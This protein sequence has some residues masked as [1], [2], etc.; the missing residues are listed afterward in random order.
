MCFLFL[1]LDRNREFKVLCSFH[2]IAGVRLRSVVGG[3]P[4][5]SNE[6]D[7]TCGSGTEAKTGGNPLGGV[8]SLGGVHFC[9]CFDLPDLL[10][11]PR[12]RCRVAL[13]TFFVCLVFFL[14][15]IF[16]TLFVKG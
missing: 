16:L 9:G 14:V 13:R 4:G 6:R 11:F 7:Q 12:R 8:H 10:V 2:S 15:A 1:P 3:Y 5:T